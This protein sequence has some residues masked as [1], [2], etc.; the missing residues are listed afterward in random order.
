MLDYPRLLPAIVYLHLSFFRDYSVPCT[1]EFG[2]INKIGYLD[3][4]KGH[5]GCSQGQL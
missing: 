1:I 5:S 2:I 4:D 3:L